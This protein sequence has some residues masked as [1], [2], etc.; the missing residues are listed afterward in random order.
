MKLR[1]FKRGLKNE[2]QKSFKSLPKKSLFKLKYAILSLVLLMS[3][4]LVGEHFYCGIY[5]YYVKAEYKDVYALDITNL[6]VIDSKD[7]Y[8]DKLYSVKQ[9]KSS[10]LQRIF[11]IQR[12]IPDKG[13][14]GGG[15]NKN[16]QHS[17]ISGADIAKIDENYIYS[18]A[19][20]ELYIY[21]LDGTLL[22]HA[23]VAK[24]DLLY[25]Y[26]DKIVI[27]GKNGVEV[28]SFDNNI[29]IKENSFT[30]E[31]YID[32][33]I[34]DNKLFIVGGSRFDNNGDYQNIYYDGCSIGNYLYEVI[35]LDLNNG[36]IKKINS[37]NAENIYV[38]ISKKH[39]FLAN[40]TY[41]R[42]GVFD[43][44]DLTIISIFNLDLSP[45]GTIR[46]EGSILDQTAMNENNNYLRIITTDI[47]EDSEKVN[48]ISIYDLKTLRKVGYLN[49]GIGVEKQVVNSIFFK[50]DECY[51]TTYGENHPYIKLDLSDVYKPKIAYKTL[52][53]NLLGNLKRFEINGEKYLLNIQLVTDLSA[54][55]MVVYK[56]TT[57]GLERVSNEYRISENDIE[58]DL[59]VEINRKAFEDRY[60]LLVVEDTNGCYFGLKADLN[61]YYIFKYEVDNQTIKVYKTVEMDE[62]FK[63]IRAF[64]KDNKLILINGNQLL[65]KD[66]DW[67]MGVSVNC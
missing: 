25:V 64:K 66:W 4:F 56:Y 41:L 31:R 51:V 59:L 20:N 39:I 43:A 65:V 33:F 22:T 45:V 61:K 55:E 27:I 29:L 48:A 62:G 10:I 40:S 28:F 13:L 32:S 35:S 36:D 34:V 6:L 44:N 2:Y 11:H 21:A 47:L 54:Y 9:L 18:I 8:E 1:D 12:Y 24:G 42:Y 30:F 49:D 7:N 19:K 58:A 14:S 63:Q 67:E 16:N 60:E 3:L 17:G 5:N 38:Y 46:V 23:E 37:L 26:E 15:N 50:E 52:D 57:N 53:A